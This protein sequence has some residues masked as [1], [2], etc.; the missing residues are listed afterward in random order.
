VF[1]YFD[2]TAKEH[3]PRNAQR[4]AAMLARRAARVPAA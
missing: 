2:N 4:L 3:A 1:C